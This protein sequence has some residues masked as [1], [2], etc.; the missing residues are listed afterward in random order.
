LIDQ[1][2]QSTQSSWP[3]KV[4]SVSDMI[5]KE[6]SE[7]PRLQAWTADR[8]D[9]DNF[10]GVKAI[11]LPNSSGFFRTAYSNGKWWL[12]TPEGHAFFQLAVDLVDYSNGFTVITNREYMFPNIDSLRA[13]YPNQ[14]TPIV[15]KP[16]LQYFNFMGANLERKYGSQIDPATGL[17]NYLQKFKDRATWRLKAWRFNTIGSVSNLQFARKPTLPFVV[18][19]RT[20]NYITGAMVPGYL[21]HHFGN[22]PDPF[23]PAFP[24]N[25]ETMVRQTSSENVHS[26]YLIGYF[27]DNELAWGDDLAGNND[28]LHYA[29]PVGALGL[30][31]DSSPAKRNFFLQ[32][33][34]KYGD[35]AKLNT[36]WGTSIP[37]WTELKRPFTSLPAAVTSELRTDFSTFLSAFAY[38]Y[39]GTIKQVLKN[40]DPNHLYLGSRYAH[41]E[42]PIEALQACIANCDVISVNYYSY[43]VSWSERLA[44]EKIG[45]PVIISEF[46]FGSADRGNFW[47]GLEDAGSEAN[48]G[49][50][51][52]TFVKGLASVPNIV[53]CDWYAYADQPTSGEPYDSGNAHNGFVSIA[54]VAFQDFAASVRNTNLNV[55]TW[56]A[57]SKP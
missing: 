33:Y 7:T 37:S 25:I 47:P 3:E 16:G 45:K 28:K 24:T 1:F 50:A 11:S 14:L 32:L 51:Y 38:R 39:Y 36:A 44:F 22:V 49:Q 40:L 41:S 12:V 43:Q 4:S 6:S 8:S 46:H 53:G 19:L 23:D 54:D 34:R 10:E 2:G 42:R 55:V 15:S 57:E 17:P 27:V 18:E 52:A 48:R 26:P 21:S 29:L 5:A 31:Y 13:Q 35:I 20:L 56:H 30:D 9:L